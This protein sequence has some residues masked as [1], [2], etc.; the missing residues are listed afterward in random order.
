MSLLRLCSAQ[1][2]NSLYVSRRP[3]QSILS[4]KETKPL[5]KLESLAPENDKSQNNEQ[6]NIK[7]RCSTKVYNGEPLID[8]E[9]PKVQLFSSSNNILRG[10]VNIPTLSPLPSPNNTNFNQVFRN[11]IKVCNYIFN[12]MLP[13]A[14]INGKMEKTKA[15]K[16]IS[17]LLSKESEVSL[18]SDQDRDLL[19]TMLS[20]NIFEQDPFRSAKNNSLTTIKLNYAE[21]SWE[22]LSLAFKI[23]NQFILLFPEKCKFD[24]VKKGILLM[25]IPDPNERDNLVLFLQNYTKVHLNQ[26]S[27]IWKQIK[28]ALTNVRYD[29]YT[30]YCV[31]PI[32]TYISSQLLSNSSSFRS[33]Y[34]MKILY[35]HLLPLFDNQNLSNYFNKLSSLII[36]IIDNNYDEQLKVIQYLLKHF[37][38]QCGQKQ[39][40]FVSMLISITSTMSSD[41]LN[42]IANKIFAFIAMSIQ[43]PNS[44]LA[45]SALSFLMKP[46]LKPIIY[47]NYE[48]AMEILHEP[49]KSAS[50][51]YWEQ[52]IKDQSAVTLSTLTNAKLEFKQSIALSDFMSTSQLI[53]KQQESNK[54]ENKDL[55]KT[56]GLLA[57]TA[58]RRDSTIDLTKSLFQIQKQF[59]KEDKNLELQRSQNQSVQIFEHINDSS[60]S[61]AKNRS[62]SMASYSRVMKNSNK[63]YH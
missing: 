54:V 57:R 18:L 44:K 2:R 39:P 8:N 37:P 52:S 4:I 6:C 34:L 14:Q 60:T 46:N 10:E 9:M 29:I 28:C 13:Q 40:L 22:H 11:K 24:L 61:L 36:Q 25:N 16:E 1:R 47:S 45:E 51:Y 23:L 30:F 53:D 62:Y 7:S 63:N 19:Y 15:L 27:N 48:G 12:F 5:P 49:L 59:K 43:L 20:K 56:W 3:Y 17:A 42:P 55:A 41:Q 31:E 33:N 50:S 21:S 58:A 38:I 32:I 35:T 26:F